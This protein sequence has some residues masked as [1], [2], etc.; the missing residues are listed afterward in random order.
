ML[1]RSSAAVSLAAILLAVAG[2]AV[3]H[4]QQRLGSHVD[5]AA[6]TTRIKADIAADRN[7]DTAAI[8]VETTDGIVML[9]G[10]ARSGLEKITVESIAMKVNGVKQIRNDV[11]V[12]P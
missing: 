10:S 5:D 7:V 8:Q 2:C 9:S 1:F 12:H 4:G 3:E 6:I 11:A